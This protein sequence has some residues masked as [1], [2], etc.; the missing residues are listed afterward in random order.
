M[1]EPQIVVLVVA[2]SSPVGHPPLQIQISGL[3]LATL[4]LQQFHRNY[5]VA[6][7]MLQNRNFSIDATFHICNLARHGQ[8]PQWHMAIF[9]IFTITQQLSMGLC[10]RIFDSACRRKTT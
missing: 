7:K 6:G 9:S 1:V 3:K 10:F 4:K 5:I 8:K 2:G